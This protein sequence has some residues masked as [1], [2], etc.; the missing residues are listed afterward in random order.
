[1]REERNVAGVRRTVAVGRTHDCRKA[2]IQQMLVVV[3]S[4]IMPS[5]AIVRLRHTNHRIRP[6]R[7]LRVFLGVLGGEMLLIRSTDALGRQLQRQL[8]VPLERTPMMRRQA[9][10]EDR[11]PMLRRR[12]ACVVVP[13][14][15]GIVTGEE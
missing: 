2:V 15:A 4:R 14:I 5:A 3:P 10:L 9:E 7:C 6:L 1:M 8:L 11:T 13:A 12:I